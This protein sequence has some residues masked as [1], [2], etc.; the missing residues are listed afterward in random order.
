MTPELGQRVVQ[1]AFGLVGSHYINGG[2][3][4][5]PDRSDGCP[6]RP[7]GIVLVA[8]KDHLN[9][10]H[11]PNKP[12]N[13]AVRAATLTIKTYAVCAGNYATFPG[14]RVTSP[15]APDLVAYLDTLK[16]T[17]PETWENYFVNFTPRRTFGPGQNGVDGNGLLVWGQSCMG[18]RHFDCV[19]FISYCY[20][21]ASGN[22]VQLEISQWRTPAPGRQ[23]FD[24]K[25]KERPAS[26]MDGDILVKAD[27]HIG[28]V[29]ADGTVIEAQDSQYGVCATAGFTF[30]SVDSNG[31]LPPK[32]WTH[33]VR[34]GGGSTAPDMPWPTGWWH[35]FD[36]SNWYYYLDANNKAMSSKTSPFNT[37][38]PPAKPHNVGVWSR[39]SATTLEITWNQVAGAPKPCT[40]T[41]YNA[42]D[43]CVQMNATSN[44]YGPLAANRMI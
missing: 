4:A 23:V 35:V 2:Y 29:T 9:P 11:L 1:I 3:G 34:L 30:P 18:I 31:N 8:D 33:L 17:E 12:A 27:H 36:G 38:L 39:P 5:T 43:L 16:S 22:V 42:S 40:E 28:F 37:R 6:C 41:F 44:L 15:T 32:S 21:Q 7:G 19:G 20:W 26:L 13:L 14:G 10:A 24:F 25:A